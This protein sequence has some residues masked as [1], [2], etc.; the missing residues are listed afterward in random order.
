MC[1]PQQHL[2]EFRDTQACSQ[3]LDTRH[4]RSWPQV[5]SE[6]VA[7]SVPVAIGR[8]SRLGVSRWHPPYQ[9]PSISVPAVR[10]GSVRTVTEASS[11]RDLLPGGPPLSDHHLARRSGTRRPARTLSPVRQMA[12]LTLMTV[13][14]PLCST[15]GRWADIS[16]LSSRVS[17]YV[18]SLVRT[19]TGTGHP[20]MGINPE[21]PRKL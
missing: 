10:N 6:P 21:R 16:S 4:Q 14:T 8:G 17:R 13:E 18:C 2:T 11:P 19:W 7:P 9:L 3:H 20:K 12:N 1:I 5:G 15:R